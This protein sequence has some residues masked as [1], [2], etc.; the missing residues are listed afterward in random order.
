MKIVM[1]RKWDVE[2]AVRLIKQENVGVAGGVPSMVTYLTLSTLVGHPLEGLLFGGAPAPPSLVARARKAFPTATMTQ[3]YGLTETNSV[4][5]SIA[6]EDYAARPTSTGRA[7]PVNDIQ[8]VHE[9]TCLPP[10]SVGEVWLRGP[11]VMKCYWREPQATDAAIT[12]DGWLRTGD[13]GYLD[14]EGFL[15]IKDRLKDIIIRGGEN[16]DSVTVENAFYADPRVLEVAAVGVP[17]ERLGE[18]VVALVSVRPDYQGQVTEAMLLTQARRRLPKF[19]VPAMVLILNATFERTP[20]GKIIIDELR[21][22]ARKHWELR[23]P[24]GPGDARL[25]NL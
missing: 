10:G 12:K 16:V 20:S 4:A 18:L 8:I 1:T 17:D 25:G 3:A 2:E 13:L 6:G 11:N 15:Y 21:K 24:P 5:V 19:A 14:D 9:N 23:R 22:I 7:C